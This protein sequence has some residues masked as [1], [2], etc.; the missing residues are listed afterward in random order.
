MLNT[1]RQVGIL[2]N[3]YKQVNKYTLKYKLNTTYNR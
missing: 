1:L 3:K 2:F